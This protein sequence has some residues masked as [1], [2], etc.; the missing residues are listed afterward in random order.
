MMKHLNNVNVAGG[1]LPDGF[2]VKIDISIDY[3]GI[4]TDELINRVTSGQSDRVRIQTMLRRMKPAELMTL[5]TDGYKLRWNDI[6]KSKI[7]DE[8]AVMTYMQLHETLTGWG[9]TD[10]QIVRV[11]AT[12]HNITIEESQAKFEELLDESE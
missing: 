3:D 7:I 8:L 4:P 6:G 11:Y 10:D 2:S 1:S 12:K 5:S 9:L